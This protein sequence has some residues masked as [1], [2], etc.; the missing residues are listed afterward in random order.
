MSGPVDGGSNQDV[1][2]NL[3]PIIDCFT[4]LITYLLVT[5][6]FLTLSSV[7]VGVAATGTGTP[8]PVESNAPPPM[9][10][11]MELKA[12]GEIGLLIRGGT[13]KKE[14]AITVPAGTARWD[15]ATLKKRLE[16]IQTKWPELT[17]VSVSAEPTVI[18]KDIVLVLHE[19]QDVMPKVYI[20]G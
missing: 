6:S 13:L 3:A 19:I 11:T 12:G 17:E 16:Q 20:S 1:D 14:I 4:V 2:L 9:V 5:A 18:Y 15:M 10:L 8:P 7:D